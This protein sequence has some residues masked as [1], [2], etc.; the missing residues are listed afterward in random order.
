MQATR[1]GHRKI[2][3]SVLSTLLFVSASMASGNANAGIVDNM[4]QSG[5]SYMDWRS[6]DPYLIGVNLT[7]NPGYWH[8]EN[9]GGG[10]LRDTWV[11]DN[12][13]EGEGP[14]V[15]PS[16]DGSKIP[17]YSPANFWYQRAVTGAAFNPYQ[18]YLS[19]FPSYEYTYDPDK[20]AA[21]GMSISNI[22]NVNDLGLTVGGFAAKTDS[23][24][25][26]R[27]T[28]SNTSDSSKS[29]E[30]ILSEFIDHAGLHHEFNFLNDG[31]NYAYDRQPFAAVSQ[32][33][34][35]WS[36][37]TLAAGESV[38]VGFTD[39]HAPAFAT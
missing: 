5:V 20:A 18:S 33:N 17:P 10:F 1:K 19:F 28:I 27:Y 15:Q 3:A 21:D 16:L 4:L 13:A 32:H 29:L 39:V 22:K 8:H 23:N 12:P 36:G 30:F 25:I 7:R 11:G 14:P 37:I 31:G 6:T 35:D 24:W 38:Q 26:Y 2:H 34:Y 9:L